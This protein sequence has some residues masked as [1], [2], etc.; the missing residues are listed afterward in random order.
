MPNITINHA[1]TYTN[2]SVGPNLPSVCNF[3]SGRKTR[4]LRGIKRGLSD[5]A[6]NRIS[7][8]LVEWFRTL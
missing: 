5:A 6:F 2:G 7:K 4:P 3:K 8:S 1:I